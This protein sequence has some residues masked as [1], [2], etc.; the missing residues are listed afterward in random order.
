VHV[1]QALEDSAQF[2]LVENPPLQ[3]RARGDLATGDR[4]D[5]QAGE[6]VAPRTV[7]LTLDSDP[8]R[9]GAS[10]LDVIEVVEGD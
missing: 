7:Q 6:A 9:T 5:G 3:V 10:E 8:V 4:G 2:G 1:V